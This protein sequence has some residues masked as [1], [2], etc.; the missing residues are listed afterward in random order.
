MDSSRSNILPETVGI[1]E[2][3]EKNDESVDGFKDLAKKKT[4]STVTEVQER[5]L[6][7]QKD[8]DLKNQFC[9]IDTAE[10]EPVDDIN[11]VCEDIRE[12]SIAEEKTPKQKFTRCRD[13]EHLRELCQTG[14]VKCGT[15]CKVRRTK[16]GHEYH[17]YFMIW[18]VL[19]EGLNIIQ[20]TLT[21]PFRICFE[22]LR[23]SF[24]TGHDSLLD[25]QKGVFIACADFPVNESEIAAMQRRLKE[26]LSHEHIDYSLIS[27]NKFY[28][29]SAVSY[30]K[31]GEKNFSEVEN[32][33]RR[34]PIQGPIITLSVS[35]LALFGAIFAYCMCFVK[36]VK[37]RHFKRSDMCKIFKYCSMMGNLNVEFMIFLLRAAIAYISNILNNYKNNKSKNNNNNNDNKKDKTD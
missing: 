12:I 33:V 31:T 6:E 17:H 21:W 5:E 14:Q 4:I 25:F 10:D 24:T 1:E 3:R 32:F 18:E 19:V 11:E 23:V 27:K 35:F 37:S 16:L 36:K 22:I 20:L 9:W 34:Y 29:Q 2:S 30:I 13:M 7:N 8:E 26:M 15:E 28:C